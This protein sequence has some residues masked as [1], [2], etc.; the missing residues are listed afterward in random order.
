[1]SDEDKDNFAKL[2]NEAGFAQTCQHCGSPEEGYKWNVLSY[3]KPEDGFRAIPSLIFTKPGTS[4]PSSSLPIVLF[5]CHQCGFTRQFHKLVLEKHLK[6]VIA[7]REAE[8]D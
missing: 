8:N 4:L 2:A 1:L 3:I 7:S 5:M 6:K